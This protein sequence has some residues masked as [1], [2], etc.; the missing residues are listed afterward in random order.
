[1]I[2]LLGYIRKLIVNIAFGLFEKAANNA[3]QKK[4]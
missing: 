1:M 2:N 4:V 3:Y